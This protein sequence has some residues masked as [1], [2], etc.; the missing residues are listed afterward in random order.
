MSRGYYY[1]INNNNNNNAQYS[2]P[3]SMYASMIFNSAKIFQ[4]FGLY[5]R[6]SDGGGREGERL[7]RYVNFT[8]IYIPGGPVKTL[9]TL[10]QFFLKSD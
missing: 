9:P 8:I 3:L 1:P 2:T 7:L 6:V 4:Y 5:F 10:N